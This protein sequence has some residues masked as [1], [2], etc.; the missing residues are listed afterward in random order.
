MKRLYTEAAINKLKDG[1]IIIQT[2][3]KSALDGSKFDINV[4]LKDKIYLVAEI[5]TITVRC[6]DVHINIDGL[7]PYLRQRVKLYV[8]DSWMQRLYVK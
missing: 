5:S 1:T 3:H 7:G 8:A 2:Y 6:K 4:K